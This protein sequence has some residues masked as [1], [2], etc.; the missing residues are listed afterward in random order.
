MTETVLVLDF[1]CYTWPLT[2]GQL[3]Q[4]KAAGYEGCI[5]GGWHGQS[6]NP[7]LVRQGDTCVAAGISVMG[8]YALIAPPSWTSFTPR[9]Q[10]RAGLPIGRAV[11]IVAVDAEVDITPDM[12]LDALTEA[13]RHGRTCLYTGGWWWN[14]FILRYHDWFYAHPDAFS[15]EPAWLA[16]YD[17]LPVLDTPRLAHLGPVVGKQFANGERGKQ[18]VGINADLNVFDRAWFFGEEDDMDEVTVEAIVD[19]ALKPVLR[20]LELQAENARDMA[21]FKAWQDSKGTGYEDAKFWAF[22]NGPIKWRLLENGWTWP[23]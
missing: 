3:R 7:Y 15:N 12:V 1:G 8:I 21:L 16:D 5:I 6:S 11:P 9:E 18:V 17:W 10:V 14:W 23:G 19:K 20:S 22:I 4:A 2:E 13:K